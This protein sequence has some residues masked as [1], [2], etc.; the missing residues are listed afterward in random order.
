MN[1]VRCPNCGNNNK[2]TNIRCE[3]CGIQLTTDGQKQDINS[4][5]TF[6]R[7]QENV[8]DAKFESFSE[9]A[10]GIGTTIMGVIFCGFLSTLIFHG[11]DIVSKI[12]IIP[13]LICGLTILFRGILMIIRGIH[14]TKKTNDYVNGNLDMNKVTKISQDENLFVRLGAIFSNIYLFGFLLFWFG[15]LI[16]ADIAAINS[17]S[18]GGCGM[19]FISLFFW[20][21]G[22]FIVISNFKKS[23]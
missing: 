22:I 21:I 23:K 12:A 10:G 11:A 13:F 14:K 1:I 6:N 8:Q 15:V 5:L 4:N 9:I 18:D 2:S 16:V 7:Q 17:W 3:I 20:F 19:F